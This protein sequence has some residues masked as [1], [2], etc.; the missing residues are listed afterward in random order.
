M[1]KLNKKPK[2]HTLLNMIKCFLVFAL[3]FQITA[4]TAASKSFDKE[5]LNIEVENNIT[6]AV[7]LFFPNNLRIA[8]ALVIVSPGS[9]GTGDVYFD[10]E[11]KEKKY[12][13]EYR[14]GL[15]KLFTDAGYA[16]AFFWQRGLIRNNQCINGQDYETRVKSYIENCYIKS[17]RGKTDLQATTLDTEKVYAYLAK[18]KFLK[19]TPLIAL[20]ISEGSHHISRLVELNK[21]SPIGIVFV[22]GM[23]DSLKSTFLRQFRQDFY[24]EKIENFF[25]KTNKDSA[26]LSDIAQYGNINTRFERSISPQWGL[27]ITMGDVWINQDIL[28]LRRTGFREAS[29]A[30]LD[31]FVKNFVDGSVGRTFNQYENTYYNSAKY[32]QQALTS[33]KNVI[34]Q[35]AHYDKKVIYLYGSYDTLVRIPKQNECF[36]KTVKCKVEIINGVGHSLEDESGFPPEK[37]LTAILMA[38]NEVVRSR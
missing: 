19:N 3:F 22:G 37:S 36:I 4:C 35:L 10:A 5:E 38:V 1:E 34:D 2:I 33:E 32:W 8:K 25:K 29:E 11:F 21:I 16:V 9:D 14:G 7:D 28:E 13:S 20:A 31:K 15:V 30:M 17:I 27:R 6:V 23:Y 12:S 26:S 18:H 24:F